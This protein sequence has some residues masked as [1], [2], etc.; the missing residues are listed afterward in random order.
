MARAGSQVWTLDQKAIRAIVFAEAAGAVIT[1][2][3]DLRVETKY[4]AGE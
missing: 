4:E 2:F 1:G 3:E